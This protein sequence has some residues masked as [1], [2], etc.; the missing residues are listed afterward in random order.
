MTPASLLGAS[1]STTTG[2]DD[3]DADR[4]EDVP[5][6]DR[7]L[8][9]LRIASDLYPDVLGGGAIHAH[10][11]SRRQAAAGHDVTVL[12]SDHGDRSAPRT[13][14]RD[15]YTLR[16]LR[17]V[18][19][20]VENSI[21]P[22]IFPAL[23]ERVPTADVVHAHSHLYFTTNASALS[24]RFSE[25]PLVLTNHGLISQT[26]PRWVHDIYLPTVGRFTFNSADRVLCYT[27]M[28]RRRLRERSID[29]PIDVIENGID[30]D[31]FTPPA[32]KPRDQALLFVGRLVDRK[33]VRTLLDAFARLSD[34]RPQLELRLVGDGPER[35]TYEARSRGLGI[36]DRVE[37]LGRVDY[38]AIPRQY[39]QS[40][41]FVLPSLNEGLPRTVLEAMACGTPVVTSSL[42]QLE[43][44]V[45]GSGYTVD[46]GDTSGFVEAIDDLLSDDDRRARMGERGRQT[47]RAEHSW[48]E[49]VRRTTNVYHELV[50]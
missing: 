47:V 43:P 40:Q 41:V 13:E 48:S 9:I 17:E 33:G 7:P 14:T 20:P 25:T 3:A 6:T 34:R 31:R 38:E 42:P 5:T 4:V 21:T 44:L 2:Y 30:C 45:A 29:A 28:D 10:A 39:Q 16:R 18:V 46:A 23:R 27:E 12:T 1:P 8:E 49:T 35:S 50:D 11:M 24:A 36:A 26:V 19:R 15:G 32:D 22:G 37:F